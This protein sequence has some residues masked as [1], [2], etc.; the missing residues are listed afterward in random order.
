MKD[1]KE[2]GDVEGYAVGGKRERVVDDAENAGL[3]TV[4]P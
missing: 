2:K 1:G 3:E 4:S